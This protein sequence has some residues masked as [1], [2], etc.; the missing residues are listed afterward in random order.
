MERPSHSEVSVEYTALA[1]DALAMRAP[2][3]NVTEML[4]GSLCSSKVMGTFFIQTR[5]FVLKLAVCLERV[6]NFAWSLPTFGVGSSRT[7]EEPR[8]IFCS[9]LR[10]N[11]ERAPWRQGA[12]SEA[13]IH[14]TNTSQQQRATCVGEACSA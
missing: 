13:S 2:Q 5:F 10:E 7:A 1:G 8:N 6:Y 11:E 3:T 4:L 14:R 12:R 9:V